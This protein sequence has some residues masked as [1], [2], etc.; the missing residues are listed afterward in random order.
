[1]ATVSGGKRSP[2]PPASW[3]RG[4]LVSVVLPAVILGLFVGA[5]TG[6]TAGTQSG[7]GGT[8]SLRGAITLGIVAAVVSGLLAGVVGWLRVRLWR[9]SFSEPLR[10]LRNDALL[11]LAVGVPSGLVAGGAAW[12]VSGV[13]H[14]LI[15]GLIVALTAPLLTS[16][17]SVR[18]A[19][20]CAMSALLGTF[21]ARPVRFMRWAYEAGLCRVAGGSYQFRHET[22]QAWLARQDDDR[23]LR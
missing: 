5:V 19:C 9:A 3:S 23:A 17:A 1:M 13:G 6:L 10:V 12:L 21:P 22:Y 20:A 15:L 7:D 14:G 18:F 4:F 16:A 11:G 2:D 8:G